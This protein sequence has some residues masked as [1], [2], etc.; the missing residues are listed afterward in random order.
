ME[1]NARVNYPIKTVLIDM[2]E[3][4]DFSLDDDHERFCVSWFSIEVAAVGIQLFVSSWSEHPI[5]GK[6]SYI[7]KSSI[8][9]TYRTMGLVLY[10]CLS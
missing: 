2:R 8:N 6:L 4:G 5:P 10:M 1:V 7:C 9:H 3:G